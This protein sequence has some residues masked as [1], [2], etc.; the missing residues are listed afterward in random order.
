[1][2][3][4]AAG[5]VASRH[6]LVLFSHTSPRGRTLIL[7]YVDDMLITG[8][9]SDYIAFDKA[10]L[11]EQFHMSDLG[12]LSYFLGIEVTPTPD[13]YY[14]SQGKYNHDL[15]DHAGLTNHRSVDTHMDIHTHLR[16]TDGVPLADPT[17]YHHLFSNLIYLGITHP[18]ISY[19]VHILSQ[20]MSTPTNVHYSHLLHVLRY[21][22]GTINHCLF[23]SSSSS[24]Q[25]HAYSYATWGSDPSDF[26]SLSTY[27][28][29]L[30]SSLIVWKTKKQTAISRSS[31]EAGLPALACVT[32]VVTW[33]WWLLADFG[34][35][36]PLHRYTMIA[37]V[38]LELLRTR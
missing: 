22:H 37:L 27:C 6:Y 16:A 2:V 19:A 15:L 34:H 20:F 28:V 36:P 29:F 14:L 5:F 1:L 8:D 13:G 11:S 26:K 9:D 21:L 33:L 4:I 32:A 31:S 35:S 12:L 10:R 3:V 38:L 7:L 23:F 18:D 17:R 24:L 30:S 25:L